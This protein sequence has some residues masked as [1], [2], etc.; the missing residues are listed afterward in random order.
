MIVAF[1]SPSAVLAAQQS[2]IREYEV[3][4]TLKLGGL[5]VGKSFCRLTKDGASQ[6][7]ST[8]KLDLGLILRLIGERKATQ[9]SLIRVDGTRKARTHEF[10]IKY[11]WKKPDGATFD[12]RNRTIESLDGEVS[13]MPEN[14]VFEWGS[15]YLNLTMIDPEDLE[16][17][18]V[19][20][21]TEDGI[22]DYDYGKVQEVTVEVD[23]RP[24][25]AKRVRMQSVENPKDAFTFW[26]SPV[27]A[28]L[29]VRLQRHKQGITVDIELN[30]FSWLD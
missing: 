13:A 18:R 7:K 6:F 1:I 27:H 2:E 8:M 24:F 15:W 9:T 22:K 29:P 3:H 17:R 25:V 23:S 21:V 11:R 30:S 28:H 12:W 5:K 19:T 16:G 26:L 14:E 20:L 10:K 4:Y